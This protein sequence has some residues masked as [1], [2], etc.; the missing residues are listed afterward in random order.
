[1]V[2]T[3]KLT[4]DPGDENFARESRSKRL[5]RLGESQDIRWSVQAGESDSV[6]TMRLVKKL[7]GIDVGVDRDS[8]L[9]GSYVGTI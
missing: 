6:L 7:T 1:M 9:V 2:V 5:V 3:T 4:R 8:F